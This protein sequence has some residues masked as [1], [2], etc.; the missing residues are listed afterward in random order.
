MAK[1]TQAKKLKRKRNRKRFSNLL[2]TSLII[3]G[4]VIPVAIS[5]ADELQQS[6]QEVQEQSTIESSSTESV[7][8]IPEAITS[9]SVLESIAI[10]P[11]SSEEITTDTTESESTEPVIES[12][13]ESETASTEQVEPE[14]T[15]EQ[16][17][18]QETI[19]SSEEATT[20]DSESN[21]SSYSDDEEIKVTIHYVDEN[22][23]KLQESDT[24][25][26]YE[27]EQKYIY[28]PDD[29]NNGTDVYLLNEEQSVP[30]FN[31]EWVYITYS[32]GMEDIT[33]VYTKTEGI[34]FNVHYVDENGT[35]LQD[36][37]T[38]LGYEGKEESVHIPYDINNGTD[39]YL[40]NEEQSVP[41]FNDEWVYITYSKGME[42]ITFVY[43]KTEGVSFNVYYVDEN[44]TEL[45]VPD[46][47]IGYEGKEESIYAPQDII[48]ETDVYT[49]NK[50]QSILE[51]NGDYTYVTYSKDM[52]DIT[53]H[54]S[55]T[56]GISFNVHYVDENGMELQNPNT[57]Y[58][59]EGKEEYIYPPYDINFG[60][61]VY[62]INK[63]QTVSE[64][65]G[66][67]VDITY[68]KDMGNITFVYTQT[69]GI[70]FN[71]H[72]VDENGK[73]LEDPDTRLGYE[74]KEEY[75]Y[76]PSSINNGTDI[77]K[78]NK[79][80][81]VPGFYNNF[82]F[83]ITY[84]KD[85]E[86][87]TFVYTQT[88]GIS[89]KVHYVDEN[90]TQLKESDTY[91]SYEGDTTFVWPDLGIH[92]YDD[93]S[94]LTG[95][96]VLNKE[97]SVSGFD[98]T[99]VDITYSKDM[100]DITFVYTKTEGISFKVHYVDENGTQLQESDTYLSYEGDT[101]Y[102]WPTRGIHVY[103]DESN[104]TGLYVLNDNQSIPEFDGEGSYVTY[105]KNMADITFVYT[106]T[107]GISFKVHYVDENGTQLQES[108]TH[109]SYEG[110]TQY[111]WADSNIQIYD[112]E[113]NLTEAYVL[114]EEQ[115][116]P[117]FDGEG[118][119][120][121]YSENMADITFHYSKIDIVSFNVHYV[122]EN[123]TQLQESDTYLSYEGDTQ[124]IWADSSIYMYDDEGNPKYIYV[125]DEEQS[126]PGFDGEEAY[127]TY[128]KDMA[129][130]T[131][132]YTKTDIISFKVH[133]IDENGT[134]L[135][136]PYTEYGY[137]G[138]EDAIYLPYDVT[139]YDDDYN[140]KDV[141]LLDEDQNIPGFDGKEISFTY[142][143]NM[144]D[145]II[146]YTK[147]EGISFKIHYVDNNGEE[148]ITPETYLSYEGNSEEIYIPNT[149][150]DTDKGGTYQLN[151]EQS[152]PGFDDSWVTITYSKFKDMPDL[153]FTYS[154]RTYSIGGDGFWYVN[155]NPETVSG[156]PGI[157]VDVDFTFVD[158]KTGKTLTTYKKDKFDI[159]Q[160]L[161][162]IE[163]EQL[164]IDTA[165]YG[166]SLASQDSGVSGYEPI[167]IDGVTTEYYSA[168]SCK[169]YNDGAG[170]MKATIPLDR[171][172]DEDNSNAF[173]SDKNTG[174][175]ITAD[176]G[177]IPENSS[178]T[179]SPITSGTEYDSLKAEFSQLQLF[180]ISLTDSNNAKVQPNGTVLVRLPI[181]E[182]FD[183]NKLRVFHVDD[184][185]SRTAMKGYVD[186]TYYVFETTHFSNFALVEDD[187]IN[188]DD[189]DTDNGNTDV[190]DNTNGD[191]IDNDNNDETDTGNSDVD[192]NN[193]G[194]DADN[195]NNGDTDTGNSD[196]DDNNDGSGA[197]NDNNGD[198][199]TGNSDVNDNTDGSGDDNDNND[200]TD[201]GNS[202]DSGRVNN[203]GNKVS[204][205]DTLPKTGETSS[206]WITLLGLTTLL[207]VVGAFFMKRKHAK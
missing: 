47:Y 79:E 99:G 124:Y 26:G 153:T 184:N 85:M 163:L 94:N 14:Q 128:S 154:P 190:D 138:K 104:L 125:L 185:G 144:P 179:V 84:S 155:Y 22:G 30:G 98:G 38:H 19:T 64:F 114:N 82:G 162:W 81:S 157:Y 152:V 60:T 156:T 72:Y 116:V 83:Y 4:T 78:L 145:F 43:T 77:Y 50:E 160:V 101:E 59:Y 194:N 58:G 80:L 5:L 40:L 141:Y 7:A 63:E 165:T 203:D 118:C 206:T 186:G 74:G 69:E 1:R 36:P 201:T 51:L 16:S 17:V 117:E 175:F 76:V 122:D 75:I 129:D 146:H 181:P 90:G 189:S 3:G 112:D 68:S 115:S 187:T 149:L 45:K 207:A 87:I 173:L 88:E 102:I 164:G 11:E 196:V 195:D 86:D 182:G 109:L 180:D 6:T 119:Y 53:L 110:D 205:E 202:G 12:T 34:S 46:T 168:F 23:T 147:T 191:D 126:V 193:D 192:D 120:V 95:L 73:E 33:F 29:I 177:V 106:Q 111:I 139:T 178:L 28:V 166:L 55:K 20:Q 188:N 49:L 183:A 56:E 57:Y 25:R 142:S 134:Q 31:D 133:Y 67:G 2:M 61:D 21:I 150:Y 131:F 91:L 171:I 137:E 15:P 199:D 200:D 13:V 136:E 62:I 96:Y 132:H 39:V 105:S 24:Y 169:Y 123:G 71:V 70:S 92:V 44:G 108:D 159:T 8:Q 204:E 172:A 107:E 197:D 10:L 42:D 167:V 9:E 113:G 52:E 66:T 151:K 143:K 121:T 27:G 158:R 100:E 170:K 65:D 140:P 93:E 48:R 37:D 97:Q 135:R 103:D 161:L 176:K 198:T 127:V 89:F 18:E 130:I 148:I 54:Y 174:S 41:G 32:K 35:E